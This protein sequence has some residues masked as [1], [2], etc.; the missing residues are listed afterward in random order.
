MKKTTQHQAPGESTS[1]FRTSPYRLQLPTRSEDHA[2]NLPWAGRGSKGW[3]MLE[4]PYLKMTSAR[5]V[6][7]LWSI[8]H[9]CHVYKK[10]I[11]N[12]YVTKRYETV[13]LFLYCRERGNTIGGVARMFISWPRVLQAFHVTPGSLRLILPERQGHWICHFRKLHWSDG[14]IVFY[15]SHYYK[16]KW[17]W[18]PRIFSEIHTNLAVFRF[19]QIGLSDIYH[20]VILGSVYFFK[21]CFSI[22]AMWV[23]SCT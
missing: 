15:K 7:F 18:L 19:C 9:G 14:S 21:S 3:K 13:A 22:V 17:W 20:F 2:S 4:D 8:C 23:D 11:Y 6:G 5:G 10:N 1:G 16:H 12:L